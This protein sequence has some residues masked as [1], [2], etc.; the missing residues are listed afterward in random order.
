MFKQILPTIIYTNRIRPP[1]NINIDLIY[2]DG[3]YYV[4]IQM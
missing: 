2:M 4:G 1:A 3:T